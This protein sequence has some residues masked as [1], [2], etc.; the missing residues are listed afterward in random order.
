MTCDS[1]LSSWTTCLVVG[2]D[3]V[4]VRCGS[5]GDVGV[6]LGLWCLPGVGG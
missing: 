5:A 1:W 3:V 6:G 2:V 4:R